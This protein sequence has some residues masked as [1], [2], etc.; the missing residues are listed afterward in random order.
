MS[1]MTKALA[2]LTLIN[3][4]CYLHRYLTPALLPVISFDRALSSQEQGY[5]V[6]AFVA[7]YFISSP[8]FGILGDRFNRTRLMAWGMVV[9]GVGSFFSGWAH[10]LGLFLLTRIIFGIG[11]SCFATIAPAYLKDTYSDTIKLNRAFS[12]FFA[13]IPI[14][15]ALGYVAAASLVN[16]I[17]WQ[18]VFV[19]TALP[20]LLLA[21]LM[22][23]MPE[24]RTLSTPKSLSY[25]DLRV[26]LCN[27][28]LM[29]AILGYVFNSFAL[30]GIA[31]F[32]TKFGMQ[33]GFE[34]ERI[35]QIFGII[36]V[37]TGFAGTVLGGLLA[38]RLA[39]GHRHPGRF[40]LRFAA[41]S[42]VAA[43]PLAALSFCSSN[44]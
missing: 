42:G 35:G 20:L 36:L 34:L 37:A 32:V 21:P 2:L 43:F 15:S 14:G 10:I 3:I 31:S 28:I 18:G 23:A 5:L 27:P 22:L 41:W 13:A 1:S 26:L 9:W 6:S 25:S 29:L 7:G 4:L 19:V 17:G 30:N 40:L 12:V 38:S 16:Y 33:I 8:L 11:E 39:K 44:R 24:V